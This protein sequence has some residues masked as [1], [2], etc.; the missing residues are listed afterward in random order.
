MDAEQAY[1]F[2][3]EGFI[4]VRQA[5]TPA[6]VAE[7]LHEA[8]ARGALHTRGTAAVV[9]WSAA[10]R[11]LVDNPK[12]SLILEDICGDRQ[13]GWEKEDR[14]LGS[15][16]PGF[17]LDHLNVHVGDGNKPSLNPQG[18]GLHGG[19]AWLRNPTAS[20]LLQP[21]YFAVDPASGAFCNGLTTVAYELEDTV[22][23]GGGF[24]CVAG[25]HANPVPVPSHMRHLNEGVHPLVTRVP[26]GA[27][28]AIIVSHAV[29]PV[30]MVMYVWLA[31]PRANLARARVRRS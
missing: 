26:A 15:S 27:G 22:C 19:N 25:S 11:A 31:V 20:K 5:I 9:H 21:S 10:Y 14:S 3:C 8:K 24:C 29:H 16:R 30:A 12:I 18:G 1:T 23:N 6:L 7:L 28:D 17:R 13:L 4:V 2:A